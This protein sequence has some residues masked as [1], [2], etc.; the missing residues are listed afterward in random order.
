[1]YRQVEHLLDQCLNIIQE[2][3]DPLMVVISLTDEKLSRNYNLWRRINK[4]AGRKRKYVKK[5]KPALQNLVPAPPL[6][7]NI[8]GENIKQET[9]FTKIL[10]ETPLKEIP[11]LSA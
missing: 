3:L 9:T 7:E 2:Q 4:S 11:F 8:I 5:Q 1:M 10:L 6:A